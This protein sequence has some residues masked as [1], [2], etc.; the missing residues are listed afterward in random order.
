[1]LPVSLH[2]LRRDDPEL[3]LQVD[4]IPLRADGFP[5]SGRSQDR[6]FQSASRHRI[7]I[8]KLCHKS[9]GVGEGQGG[10]MLNVLLQLAEPSFDKFTARR[11]VTV[12]REFARYGIIHHVL[13]AL[14]HPRSSLGYSAPYRIEHLL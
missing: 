11:I 14:L 9:G 5:G 2:S 13:D 7:A 8:S 3:L 12:L 4:L 10:M 6:K 1:M